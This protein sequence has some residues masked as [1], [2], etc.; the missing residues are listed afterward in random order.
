MSVAVNGEPKGA[1]LHTFE[2]GVADIPVELDM[3][4]SG[5]DLPLVISTVKL[6]SAGSFSSTTSSM[7]KPTLSVSKA[8]GQGRRS[9]AAAHSAG[10]DG[11][12]KYR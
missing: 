5:N 6:Q 10:R 2:K 7:Q 11:Q 12:D 1:V 8:H 3:D 4:E 9:A